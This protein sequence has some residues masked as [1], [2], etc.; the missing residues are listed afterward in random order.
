MRQIAFDSIRAI[1]VDP[2]D[3]SALIAETVDDDSYADNPHIRDFVTKILATY[4]RETSSQVILSLL[5]LVG[6]ITNHTSMQMWNNMLQMSNI[7]LGNMAASS[8][9][10]PENMTES[11][12]TIKLRV[13]EFLDSLGVE[14]VEQPHN[15]EISLSDLI[16]ALA[17][18]S[19]QLRSVELTDE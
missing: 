15:R 17:S 7:G 11:A 16:V 18:N 8:A 19:V 6:S 14:V 4:T 10:S 3:V 13:E 2:D 12:K 1:E 9:I 5:Q